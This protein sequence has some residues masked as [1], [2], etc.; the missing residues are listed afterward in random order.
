MEDFI[1]KMLM[2]ARTGSWVHSLNGKRWMLALRCLQSSRQGRGVGRS[3]FGSSSL[4]LSSSQTTSCL[5]ESYVM[6]WVSCA[7]GA[8]SNRWCLFS[9]F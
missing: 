6:A 1:D 4:T 7:F 2:I 9:S 8:P 5:G 3:V